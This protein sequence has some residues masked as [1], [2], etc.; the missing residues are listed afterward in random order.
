MV[1]YYSRIGELEEGLELI[2]YSLSVKTYRR[3]DRYIFNFENTANFD[4]SNY[5]LEKELQGTT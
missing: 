3:K 1:K 4:V 5:C 2:I